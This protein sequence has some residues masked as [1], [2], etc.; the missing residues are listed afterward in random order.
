MSIDADEEVLDSRGRNI[1]LIIFGAIAVL[2]IGLVWNNYRTKAG[3]IAAMKSGSAEAQQAAAEAMMKRGQIAE[4]LQGQKP[5]VRIAAVKS[6]ALVRTPEGAD[7]LFQFMKDPD[8]PVKDLTTTA[9]INLGPDVVLNPNDTSKDALHP[10]LDALANS[11]D[12][13]KG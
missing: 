1:T 5:S 3:W 6:L 11:D 12:A 2:I 8:S 10:G 9:L 13:V 7:Q 4:Q